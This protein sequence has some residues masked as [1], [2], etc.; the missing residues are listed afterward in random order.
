MNAFAGLQGVEFTFVVFKVAVGKSLFCDQEE[1]EEVPEGFD[2]L[3]LEGKAAATFFILQGRESVFRLE[4]G[5][6]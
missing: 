2:S 5:G 6:S 4:E 3:C 1:P